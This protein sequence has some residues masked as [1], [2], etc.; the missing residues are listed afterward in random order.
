MNNSH[1]HS[2]ARP[3][4]LTDTVSYALRRNRLTPDRGR[5]VT[6]TVREALTKLALAQYISPASRWD[7]HFI[8]T[9][10]DGSTIRFNS[11][12]MEEAGFAFIA[13]EAEV[14]RAIAA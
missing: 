6:A 10:S 1:A 3:L 4:A 7:A 9:R 2:F 14:P 5:Y 12:D 11:L 13:E 8:Y